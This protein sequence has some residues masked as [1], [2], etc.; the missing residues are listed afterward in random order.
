[1]I[2]EVVLENY[3]PDFMKDYVEITETLKA[4]NPEFN[5]IWEEVDK[6]L[7]NH[8]ISEADKY[9]I[10]RFENILGI[11]PQTGDTLESRRS[12][13]QN[14]W[15]NDMPGTIRAFICKMEILCAGT[16]FNI[17]TDFESGYTLIIRACLEEYGKVEELEQIINSMIPCNIVV[18]LNNSIIFNEPVCEN[19]AA[20][21]VSAIQMFETDNF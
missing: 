2:R 9:G 14:R 4:E 20:G 6:V 5:I 13:V 10:S 1:M 17:D 7:Y 12:R 15:F 19:F 21:A 18:N 3:L 16:D 8:F 11:Y